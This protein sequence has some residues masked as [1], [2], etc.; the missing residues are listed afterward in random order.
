MEAPI[1]GLCHACAAIGLTPQDFDNPPFLPEEKY[2]QVVRSGTLGDLRLKENE[3]G[4]CRLL[5]HALSRTLGSQ[6]QVLE[7]SD[8]VWEAEW[9]QNT[10]EYDPMTDSSDD[11]FGSAI[12]P[13][14]KE[15]GQSNYGVQLLYQAVLGHPLRS[16]PVPSKMD[17]ARMKTWIQK[18]QDEHG[19]SCSN[20]YLAIGSHPST[21]PG[22]MAIHVARKCLTELPARAKYVALSYVWGSTNH[23]LTIKSNLEYFRKEGAFDRVHLAKTIHHAIEVTACL[24]FDFLWVDALCIVQDD[25]Q[26]KPQLIA[27]MDAIY[28]NAALTILA[29]SGG[30]ANAGLSG[31]ASDG[32]HDRQNAILDV[33]VGPDL[34]LTVR[35]LF[36]TELM[37]APH[38]QRGWT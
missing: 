10:W 5:L 29:A 24:G 7:D 6:P 21:L 32:I 33:R 18:C 31:W 22:F 2:H 30:H 13:R 9:M 35:P 15:D 12:Y 16:R 25:E 4:L 28:G 26:Y 20:P 17:T 37:D 3:C 11:L 36:D 34:H 8:T 19:E 27:N 23:P 1:Q 38:S 14:L